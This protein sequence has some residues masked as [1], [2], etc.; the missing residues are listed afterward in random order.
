[1]L[2]LLAE[3]IET[4]TNAYLVKLVTAQV[5]QN[6]IVNGFSRVL[7]AN[8][9]EATQSY[10][11]DLRGFEWSASL[12]GGVRTLS[13]HEFFLLAICLTPPSDELP[14]PHPP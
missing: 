10:T 2:A 7:S 6:D 5:L 3:R 8:K 4:T 12:T 13:C 9:H 11:S 1:M 14:R